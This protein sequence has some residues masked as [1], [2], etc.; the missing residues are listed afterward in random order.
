MG[1]APIDLSQFDPAPVLE[2][3][4][5]RR[6]LLGGGQVLG[7]DEK[8]AVHLIAACGSGDVGEPQPACR[9]ARQLLAVQHRPGRERVGPPRYSWAMLDR[10]A[11]VVPPRNVESTCNR[12]RNVGSVPTPAATSDPA[13]GSSDERPPSSHRITP[14]V[15]GRRRSRRHTC[16]DGET[17]FVVPRAQGRGVVRSARPRQAQAPRDPGRPT[18]AKAF[19]SRC[20]RPGRSRTSRDVRAPPRR[21]AAAEPPVRRS[22]SHGHCHSYVHLPSSARHNC[23]SSFMARWSR[24][25]AAPGEQSMI[26]AISSYPRSWNRLSTRTSRCSGDRR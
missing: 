12:S 3:W 1:S 16:Q 26:L 14:R 5:G 22:A 4:T 21:L 24:T 25:R 7:M 20:V 17:R 18:R 13:C 23:R 2:V 8:E 9:V 11:G 19:R 10:C 15:P 6:Y